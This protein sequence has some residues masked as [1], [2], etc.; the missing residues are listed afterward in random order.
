MKDL[1]MV[2]LVLGAAIAGGGLIAVWDNATTPDRT[3]AAFLHAE[4]IDDSAAVDGSVI[5]YE[6]LTADQQTVFE[7]A[8]ADDLN[9]TEIPDDTN[10][11]V[12]YDGGAVSYQNR[13][14]EVAVSE[15]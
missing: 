1:L 5:G 12:W 7:R 2:G 14:Y 9:I 8:I 10:A 6:N 15:T 11:S 13:T 3:A 4:Q